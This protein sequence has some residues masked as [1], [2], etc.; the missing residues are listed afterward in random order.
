M[1]LLGPMDLIISGWD[2][3]GFSTTGF[4][5]GLSNIKFGLFTNMV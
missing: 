3:E 5:E 4:G 2:C 1:E